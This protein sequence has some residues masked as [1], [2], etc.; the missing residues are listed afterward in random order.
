MMCC[1]YTIVTMSAGASPLLG[2]LGHPLGSE[3]PGARFAQSLALLGREP[4]QLVPR[5]G[6]EPAQLEVLLDCLDGT[7]L[8][9]DAFS[10]P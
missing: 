4:A 1:H 3:Q 6:A 8:L 10:F 7:E 5:H 9:H 2:R